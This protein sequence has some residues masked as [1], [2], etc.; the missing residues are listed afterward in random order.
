MSR[1]KI[2][3]KGQVFLIGAIIIV[4]VLVLIRTSVNV[5]DVVQRKNFIET[6][7]ER[8]E[9]D[10]IRS[11]V[12]KSASN[13]INDTQEIANETNSFVAF[14]ED[15]LNGR[16]LQLDGATVIVTYENLQESTDTDLDVTLYNFFDAD[17][18]NATLNLSTDFS[19]PTNFNTTAAGETESAQFTLNLGSSQNLTLWVFYEVSGRQ[20]VQNVTIPAEISKTKSVVYADLRMTSERGTLSDRFSEVIH[21][22]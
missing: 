5:A 2:P 3:G 14:A 21:V 13:A 11:E 17:M 16:T 20:Y 19:S 9:F 8:T 22:N 18:L 12:I 10:N 15:K 6:G 4:L 7:L 1:E